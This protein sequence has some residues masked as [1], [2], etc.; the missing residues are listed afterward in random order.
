ML[1]YEKVIVAVSIATIVALPFIRAWSAKASRDLDLAV[2]EGEK[3]IHEGMA[4]SD[5][6]MTQVMDAAKNTHL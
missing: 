1:K 3:K 6:L 4:E 2:A 5:R